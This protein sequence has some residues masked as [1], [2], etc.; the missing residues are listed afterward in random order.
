VRVSGDRRDRLQHFLREQGIDTFVYYPV[1]LHLLPLYQGMGLRLPEA[2]RASREVL[3]L[4]MGPLLEGEAQLFITSCIRS[5][6]KC[7]H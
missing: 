2:E 1:P 3:S 6:L 7:T 5:A 4:P